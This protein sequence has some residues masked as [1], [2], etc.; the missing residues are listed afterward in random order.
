MAMK[1]S[2][3]WYNHNYHHQVVMVMKYNLAGTISIFILQSCKQ[4]AKYLLLKQH[5]NQKNNSHCANS[6]TTLFWTS[7]GSFCL[8][9]V[10]F[11]F[12]CVMS[13]KP[14][15]ISRIRLQRAERELP[16]NK[17]G[18]L[19]MGAKGG[20][21]EFLKRTSARSARSHTN[22]NLLSICLLKEKEGE[23]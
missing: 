10:I 13:V 5:R 22:N 20:L 12:P 16:G 19:S 21:Q 23:G 1:K 11:S 6:P 4:L 3:I 15:R 14:S 2:I 18:P 9:L 8:A 17:A 7:N